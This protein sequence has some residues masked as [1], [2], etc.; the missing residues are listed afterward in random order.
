MPCVLVVGSGGREHAILDALARSPR[1]PD[2]LCAPGNAGT[3]SL[4][5][6]LPIAADDLDAL[7]DV[8]L[9]RAVD[10]VVIGPEVPLAAGLADRLADAEIPVVGPTAAAARLESSKAFAK[11]FMAR[12]GVPTAACRTFT[13]DA[14]DDAR[15]YVDAHPL[16][17]VLKAD[18]LAAGKGVLIAGTRDG[19]HEG[20]QRLL[21]DSEF[22]EASAEVVIEAFI[23]GEEASVFALTDGTDYVLLAPAQDH[24]RIGEGDTGPTTGGMGAYAPAPLVTPVL[25]KQ[26]EAE[27][28]QP[29]LRGMAAEGHPYRGILYVGLMISSAGPKVVEFNVRF[30]DPE[31]QVVLPLLESD[32]LDHFE[33]LAEGRIASETVR[34]RDGAAACVILA[35]AGYPG[36]YEKGKP[37]NGLD[38]AAEHALVFHAG[39]KA[40]GEQVITNGGRVLGLTGLGADLQ[41]ALDH[42]Y[43]AAAAIQFEGKTLRRDI[44]QKGL[45]RLAAP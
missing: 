8:A 15:A 18:G 44:G 20:L 11:A 14:Y 26:V 37:I 4:A 12:H 3:A 9:A 2:L 31:T 16:P 32:L 22:G 24:K 25:M 23:V 38:E 10:L 34:L 39:T 21:R 19:A 17:V 29:V 41:E 6:N 27:I 36:S 43:A 45:A 5:E 7:V 40:H 35:S 13:R 28:I 42:A 1:Q 30:G 33:A